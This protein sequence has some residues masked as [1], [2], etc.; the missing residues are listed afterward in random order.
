MAQLETLLLSVWREAARHT[1]IATSTTSIAQLLARCMPLQQV[2]V[3]RLE[4]ERSC[5][6]TV[7]IGTE[8]IA[9]WTLGERSEYNPIQLRRLQAWCHRGETALRGRGARHVMEL[10]VAVPAG[11][12]EELLVGPLV[13]EHG[14]CGVILLLAT[15]AQHFT[16]L[17]QQMLQTVLELVAAALENDRRLREL[18][19][20]REAAEAE[21]QSLLRRLGRTEV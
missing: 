10:A 20:V 15:P 5:L 17:H 16:P 12:D 11:V 3:R 21:K 19:V 18:T 8:R 4:P 6:E 14:T 2:L 1:D 9:P 13:S 7:G